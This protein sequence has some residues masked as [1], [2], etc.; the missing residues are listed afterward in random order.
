M[1]V[2]RD[3]YA[4]NHVGNIRNSGNSDFDGSHI[5]SSATAPSSTVLVQLWLY[6]AV[7]PV[8]PH[9][10]GYALVEYFGYA[11]S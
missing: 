8:V 1:K 9:A 5:P 7:T 4:Q 6:A 11:Q 3:V 2:W 10:I